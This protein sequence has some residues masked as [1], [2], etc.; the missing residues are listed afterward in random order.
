MAG[1]RDVIQMEVKLDV[2]A[3]LYKLGRKGE[4]Y[5]VIIRRLIDY[6]K[7]HQGEIR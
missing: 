5:S 2:H 3:D 7:L 4:S 1:K 6:Y